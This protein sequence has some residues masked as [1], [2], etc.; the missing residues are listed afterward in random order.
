[1]IKEREIK[2]LNKKLIEFSVD[3]LKNIKVST[4]LYEELTINEIKL[5]P[6]AETAKLGFWES[7]LLEEI[8]YCSDRVFEIFDAPKMLCPL[9]AEML[10]SR[11]HKDD[12]EKFVAA[13]QLTRLNGSPL[14][15]TYR[16]ITRKGNLKILHSRAELK[17]DIF[18]NPEKIIGITMDIT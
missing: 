18:G 9:P 16:V 2:K 4:K 10:R 6:A 17:Y 3:L 1:M 8:V 15:L 11:I 13:S 7:N 14:D 12:L 5:K